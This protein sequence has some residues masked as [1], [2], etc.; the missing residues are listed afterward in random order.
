MAFFAG[1]LLIQSPGYASYGPI[2]SLSI[3]VS[4]STVVAHC[5]Q[6]LLGTPTTYR[7]LEKH[8]TRHKHQQL[9]IH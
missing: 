9:S 8:V 7:C 5:D 4:L 1:G 6:K 2:V 3:Y